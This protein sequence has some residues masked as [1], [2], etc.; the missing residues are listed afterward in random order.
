[1]GIAEPS[2]LI[3]DELTPI[4]RVQDLDGER[5]VGEDTGEGSKHNN[6]RTAGDRDDCG[7][8]RTAVGDREGGTLVPVAFPPA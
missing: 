1:M 2:Q 8:P 5:Q 3:I 6:L 7:P 4:I